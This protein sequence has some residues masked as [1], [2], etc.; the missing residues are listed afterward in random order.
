MA[1]NMAGD[2]PEIFRVVVEH[3]EMVP[4]PEYTWGG[5]SPRRFPTGKTY[6]R[7]Y[8]PYRTLAAARGQMTSHTVGYGGGLLDHVVSGSIQ[9]AETTWRYVA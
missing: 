7:I 6:T 1:R 3:R 4:N 8:G 5:N 2:D 9:R